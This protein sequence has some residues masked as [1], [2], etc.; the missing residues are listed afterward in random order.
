MPPTDVI[1]AW[2]SA[3]PVRRVGC[4][5]QEHDSRWQS[6]PRNT[7][8]PSLYL[9]NGLRSTQSRLELRASHDC[10]CFPPPPANAFFILSP[11]LTGE[12]HLLWRG[13]P[14]AACRAALFEYPWRGGATREAFRGAGESHGGC[15]Q[16]FHATEAGRTLGENQGLR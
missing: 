1:H 15:S 12:G 9:D 7:N 8:H 16:A 14:G 5:R 11:P 4:R 3:S 13:L 6:A 2:Y 10:L